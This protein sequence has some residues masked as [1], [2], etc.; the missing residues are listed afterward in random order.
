VPS[1]TVLHVIWLDG[2]ALTVDAN[3]PTSIGWT[4]GRHGGA[5]MARRSVVL[6]AV[7]SDGGCW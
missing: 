7:S 5:G 1:Q 6:G 4:Q 3:D 2:A